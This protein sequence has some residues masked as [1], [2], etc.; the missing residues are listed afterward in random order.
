MPPESAPPVPLPP[1]PFDL[2]VVGGGAAGL[3]A[4]G[5]AP[6]RG[7]RVLLLEKN[8]R[9]GVKV[10]A[11]GGGHCNLTTTLPL[12]ATLEAFGPEGARFL[13]PSVRRLP[14]LALREAFH[15]LGVPTREGELEKVWPVSGKARDVLEALVRR[16]R[17]AGATIRE[18]TAV[19]SIERAGG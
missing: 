5:T 13:A 17:A 7:R 10:L 19:L 8:R 18:G 12:A 9:V 2:L 14:P 11:S 16:A 15:A 3:W 1:G 4:A 6:A